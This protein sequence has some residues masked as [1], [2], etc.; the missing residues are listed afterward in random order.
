M[1]ESLDELAELPSKPCCA[2][3]HASDTGHMCD[4]MPALSIVIKLEFA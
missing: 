2:G 1:A 3:S 4:D